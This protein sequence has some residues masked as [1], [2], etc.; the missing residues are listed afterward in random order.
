MTTRK[1]VWLVVLLPML[2]CGG[3][4]G[5]TDRSATPGAQAPDAPVSAGKAI[6]GALQGQVDP[7]V[8]GCLDLVGAGKFSEAIPACLR[9]VSVDP[10]NADVQEAL[11]TARSQIPAP[12]TSAA[13][14][15]ADEAAGKAATELEKAKQGLQGQIPQ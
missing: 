4:S 9:A 6:T 13:A 1:V 7:N 14:G 12:D 10:N 11:K 8:T 3:E 5:T 2:A 15:A